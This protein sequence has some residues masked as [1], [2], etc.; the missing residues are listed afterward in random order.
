MQLDCRLS[1]LP[2]LKFC[3]YLCFVIITI[4]EVLQ[5]AISLTGSASQVSTRLDTTPARVLPLLRTDEVLN[6][7]FNGESLSG[8]G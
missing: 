5:G 8:T 2:D 3:P 1:V 4:T 7:R 6:N